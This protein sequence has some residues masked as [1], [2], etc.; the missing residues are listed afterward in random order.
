MGCRVTASAGALSQGVSETN[1][2]VALEVT[3]THRQGFHT[4]PVMKFVD[5][6]QR[7]ASDVTVVSLSKADEVVNGKSAMELM[8]LAAAQGT[9][10]RIEAS[11]PDAD[12]AVKSLTALV[13]NHFEL[14][15]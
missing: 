7:F 12:E 1:K 14:D 11:G 4:R 6:A 13:R 8:L 2:R 15:A 9:R 5:L 10:L 3:V